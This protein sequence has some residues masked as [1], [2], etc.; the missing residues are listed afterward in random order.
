MDTIV[1]LFQFKSA[2]FTAGE[3]EEAC[4]DRYL[5]AAIYFG[6]QTIWVSDR[7]DLLV[8]LQEYRVRL[9]S[10]GYE[11]TTFE[12]ASIDWMSSDHCAVEVI[13][14][15]LSTSGRLISILAGTY[16]C[17]LGDAGWSVKIVEFSDRTKPQI[18]K[19]MSSQS[20]LGRPI[21]VH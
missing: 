6:D 10:Q 18:A 19:Q 14:H 9:V 5:P 3:L 8:T 16:F 13:W 1:E 4:S 12:I 20:K 21:I 2:C 7:D 15:N 17:K 11:R